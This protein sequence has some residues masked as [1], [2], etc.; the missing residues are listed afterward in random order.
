MKYEIVKDKKDKDPNP[1]DKQEIILNIEKPQWT[2]S[3]IALSQD[4][5][6]QIDEM[7]AYTQHREKLLY[8]WEFNRFMK[9]GCGLSINFFGPPGTGKSITA[10][11]IAHKLKVNIA[12][13]DYGEIESEFPG[14]TSKHLS[15]VFQQAEETKTLLFFDEADA[16]LSKRIANLSQAADHGVNA[17]KSTLL[18]LLD[19]FNGVIV[20]AT[21]LFD[22][23]DEA[24]LR[25][26]IFNVEFPVPDEI[27]RTKL[28]EFHLF[29]KI[30]RDLSYERAAEIS[31]GLCG[32]DIKNITIKLGLKLLA[33]KATK[34]DESVMQEEIEKYKK[35]KERH[36]KPDVADISSETSDS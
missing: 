10:E 17:A 13:I 32:G 25:R 34:I 15:S 27:M 20:F 23:Y 16:L 22:N 24:F 33:G 18:T 1:S 29:Q 31:D 7:I 12:K 19:K 2:L 14:Q 9:A 8:E 6:D 26:I 11:A 21:N 3:E 4:T 35:I 5:L 28:W 30:P 36:K